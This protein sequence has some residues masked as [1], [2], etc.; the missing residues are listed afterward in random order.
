VGT[1][2][3][4]LPGGERAALAVE[5]VDLAG[6]VALGDSVAVNGVCLTVTSIDPPT[7]TFD[8][9]TETLKKS[10]LGSLARG[11]RV[12][13][14]GALKIGDRLS[15]HFV[16]GH[17]DGVGEVARRSDDPGQ[18]TLT[19][20]APAEVAAMVIEKGSVA[21]DG[22][23]LTTFD[24]GGGLFSVALVPHTLDHTILKDIRQ[25]TP[26]NLEAD[27]IARWVAKLLPGGES[28]GLTIEKLRDAGYG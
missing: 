14:E 20:R 11:H 12:N 6:D 10:T 1:I 19:V 9:V 2:L 18:V 8:V 21:I 17:V 24:V 23:S 5:T 25:G 3:S 27:I 22:V 16:M 7:L 15:G 4:V 28:G 13:L 26:V